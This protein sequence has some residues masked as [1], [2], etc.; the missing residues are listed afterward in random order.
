MSEILSSLFLAV[1]VVAHEPGYTT[2]LANHLKRWLG[3]ES[4]PARVVTPAQMPAALATDRLAFLVGFASPSQSEMATLR[5]FRARGGKLVVFHSSAPALASMMGVRPV[6]Y[7]AA[8][9]PGEWS[10]MDFCT[11]SPAG[12]PGSIRQTS[13]VLNR[14]RAVEGRSRVIATW[15]NRAGRATG[16]P[17]WIASDAGYWMTHVLLADGDED[18]KAQLLGAIVGSVCPSLWS[19]A[20]HRARQAAKNQALLEHAKR[21]VPVLGEIHATWDHSGCGLYPGNWPRTMRVLRDAHVTDLFVNVAGAGFAHYPSSILPQS[22]T[23]TQEGDQLAACL[24]AAKGSGV[25]VHAWVICFSGTR[26]TPD[27]QETFRRRGWRLKTP[28]G[29]LTEYLDPSNAA[30]REYVLSAV[31]EIQ[32]RYQVAGI[33]L[34]FVRWGD[35]AAKPKNAAG[36][37]SQFV[38]EARRRVRRPKWL[39]TAVYGRYPTCI[40]TVGQDWVGWL[41]AGVVDY[42]VPMDYTESFATFEELLRQHA[43]SKSRARRTI[44]GI[45]VT[46]NESRLDARQVMDQIGLVRR[47]GLAGEALFDLDVTLEKSIFPYLRLGMW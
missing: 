18:M 7:R 20:S 14:A 17:A 46:A 40:A 32:A 27:R 35:T 44:V 47:Y 23:Y 8:A 15:S 24:A 10:R 43:A 5:A 21:Q 22:K 13:T 42:V 9:Y 45:G 6:G 38:A 26:G 34:D 16:E 29:T 37:V 4:V 31:D 39:T 30:V 19:S 3:T 33:H 11:K 1:T 12:L 25:R 28:K 2:S 41:N 36:V